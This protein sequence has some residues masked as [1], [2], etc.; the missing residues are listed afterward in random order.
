M[1]NLDLNQYRCKPTEQL[2]PTAANELCDEIQRLGVLAES[3][4]RTIG[5]G[6]E[7]RHHL[8]VENAKLRDAIIRA[9]EYD[10]QLQ[11]AVAGI[12]KDAVGYKEVEDVA[13]DR[14]TV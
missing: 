4:H 10:T 9:I 3:Q 2:L 5:L 6:I 12:L 11:R 8:E 7:Y 13:D 1:S 14:D